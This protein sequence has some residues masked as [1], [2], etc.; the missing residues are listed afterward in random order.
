[1]ALAVL[2]LALSFL[3]FADLIYFRYFK[4]FI[5]VP[6]LLQAGQV[7]ELQDSIWSLMRPGDWI[8]FVDLPFAFALAGWILWKNSA[9]RALAKQ[10]TSQPSRTRIGFLWRK[11]LPATLVFAIGWA[12]VYYPVEEQKNG[13]ARGLFVGNWWNVP[14]Y[15]VT[16]LLGFHGYDAYRYAKENWFGAN[17]SEE[18]ILE[19]KNWFA[20]RRQLQNKRR[21]SRCSVIMQARTC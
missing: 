12:L 10:R 7:G 16:G 1:M 8:Y 18:Q 20:D 6:V 17:L 11:L 15:N 14:I 21:P 4:D 13:W 9:K 3:I 19:T 2:D 5:S